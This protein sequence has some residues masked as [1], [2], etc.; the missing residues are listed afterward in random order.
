MRNNN[1]IPRTNNHAEL[2]P[3]TRSKTTK[4]VYKTITNYLMG[5]MEYRTR[6]F[7]PPKKCNN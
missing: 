4:N 6:K 3:S 7:S 5:K 1:K 2:L